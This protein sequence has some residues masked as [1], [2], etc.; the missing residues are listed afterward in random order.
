MAQLSAMDPAGIGVDQNWL[1]F[2][3]K[4]FPLPNQQSGGDGLNSLGYV[5]NAPTNDNL[6]N[7]VG[8]VDYTINDSMKL[9]ARFTIAREDQVYQPNEFPGDPVTSPETDRS[10]SFVLGHNWVIG[11]NKTNRFFVGDVVQKVAFPINYNPTGT[12]A[13]TFGD[14][15]DQSL[16]SN[17]YIWPDS[18]ARRVP[19]EQLGDDFTWIKG[20]HTLQMGGRIEDILAHSTNAADFNT[21]EVG[22]GGQTFSLCGP[23]AGACGTGNPSLRPSD[24]DL[25]NKFTWDEPFAPRSR[26]C[27]SRASQAPRRC[28]RPRAASAP[29]RPANP[30]G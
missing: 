24:L 19:I 16:T 7:Y 28:A 23:A 11:Q 10:Y 1:A 15:A 9:F 22:L 3:N 25:G 2:I 26:P 18:Q 17:P 20:R 21:T 12:T 14:G 6:T 5:F 13:F 4:R 8:R 27:R 30:T 29:P